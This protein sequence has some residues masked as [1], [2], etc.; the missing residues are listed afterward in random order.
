MD[1]RVVW[2]TLLMSLATGTVFGLAPALQATRPAL[3]PALKDDGGTALRSYRRFGVRNVLV[4][5]QVAVSLVLLTAAGLFV[6]SL[7]RAQDIDPGFEREHALILTTETRLSGIPRDERRA[8]A[9]RLRDRLSAIPGVQRVALADR[10]P[11]GAQVRTSSV[12]VDDQ[13]PDQNGRGRD[14]DY[15]INDAGYFSA[16]G[17]PLLRGRDFNAQ[18]DKAAPNV[19]I[20]SEA[21]AKQF[22][23]NL[24]PIGRRVR[25]ANGRRTESKGDQADAPMTVVGI[26][27]DTKVRTLGEDPRPYLYRP[28]RQTDEEMA[29]VIRTAGDP[30]LL[31]NTVRQTALALNSNLLI[32]SLNTMRQHLSLMLTP[33][34]IA[35]AMLGI[36]GALAILLA[37]LGLYAVVAFAAARRTKEI[38][39]RVAL[40][41]SP[42]HVI[43]LV[44]REGM[45][46]VAVGVGI[47]F[48]LAAALSRPLGAYLYG[49]DG[50]DPITF[51][52]VAAVMTG[53]ALV[54]NYLP[55]RRAVR[56]DP[57]TAIRYE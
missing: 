27:R 11:L 31:V 1:Q 3:L 14:V 42:S 19:A 6:R 23:P 21:F 15:T 37:S 7:Q 40:G 28:W 26:A 4:V 24:D 30:A 2:F 57:L 52:W 32:L 51:A 20:V 49:L 34:R 36:F 9:E 44:V 29:F 50:L 46:L 17:I 5:T 56:V 22:W 10:V 45:T 39:I 25:F 48:V 47:G 16:L 53:T 54:A 33:P 12:L 8:F 55:A 38:G 18:D 35:A 43:R 13:Q 41:A